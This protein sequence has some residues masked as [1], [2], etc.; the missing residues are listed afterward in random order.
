VYRIMRRQTENN[1]LLR[2]ILN[3]LRSSQ[4]KPQLTA[5]ND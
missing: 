1:E 2:N 5:T 3:E 4:G